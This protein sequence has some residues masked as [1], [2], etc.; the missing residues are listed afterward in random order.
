[1]PSSSNIISLHSFLD[2]HNILRVGGRLANSKLSF[3]QKYPII[4]HQKDLI[5]RLIIHTQHIVLLHAGPTLL[6]TSLSR[7]YHIIGLRGAVRS[8][9]RQCVICRRQS[10]K[11]EHQLMG[12]LPLERINPG[13]IFENVSLDYAGPISIKYGYVR[14]PTVVKAYVAVF[15]SLSVRAVHLELVSDLTSEAFIA[16]LRRFVAHRGCPNQIWSDHGTNF[17]GA[18]REIGEFYEFLSNN[19]VQYNVSQFCSNRCIEW[20][21]IL[22]GYGRLL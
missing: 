16:C 1:M 3:S 15:I 11:A 7:D 4:L 12:Q 2:S 13:L 22:E 20:R 8:V 5:V 21:P 9:T 10:A 18:N 19:I 6:M 14:K 17:V